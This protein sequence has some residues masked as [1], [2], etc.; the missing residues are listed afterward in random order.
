MGQWV[1]MGRLTLPV[2][3]EPVAGEFFG[4]DVDLD[5]DLAIVGANHDTDRGSDAGAAYFFQRDSV[6]PWTFNSKVM[7]SDTNSFD[8]FGESVSISDNTAV[9]GSFGSASAYVFQRDMV[10]AWNQATKLQ[11]F[12]TPNGDWF[13]IDVAIDD[14][15]IVAGASHDN[16]SFGSIYVFEQDN[17]GTWNSAG[18]L[19]APGPQTFLEL[20]GSV[21]IS[22]GL[23]IGG[24]VNDQ[25]LAGSAHVFGRGPGG[26][27]HLHKLKASDDDA[28]DLFS[29]VSLD[30]R[31]AIVGAW[32]DDHSARFDAGAAY[33]FASVPEPTT[34]ILGP[35]AAM[36]LLLS[37]RRNR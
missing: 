26:W 9:I 19:V 27:Q 8:F 3:F 33:V 29:K 7:G 21:A 28:E 10:G 15:T 18:K 37:A 34:I 30:G 13:G 22:D 16:S 23:V 36:L 5:G 24:A 2:G 35:I 17:L 31:V 6:G 20:G 14:S 4:V 12:D 32:R 25:N 11:A 1:N